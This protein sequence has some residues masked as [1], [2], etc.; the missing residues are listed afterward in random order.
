MADTVITV[1]DVVETC[2][3]SPNLFA[4]D[5]ISRFSTLID[6]YYRYAR[7]D[8]RRAVGSNI[9]DDTIDADRA[10]QVQSAVMYLTGAR[11]L[12][13]ALT[14]HVMGV[15][16]PLLMAQ[17]AQVEA[18]IQG[19]IGQAGSAIDAAQLDTPTDGSQGG[20]PFNSMTGSTPLFTRADAW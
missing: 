11:M 3:I 19:L 1:N 9:F 8:V 10:M 17:P 7:A 6:R 13:A 14:Q 5:S 16:P 12:Q 15:G 20:D 2:G 18:T 4:I